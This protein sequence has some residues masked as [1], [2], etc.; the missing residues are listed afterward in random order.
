MLKKTI[1]EDC[2]L[3]TFA[4]ATLEF[5]QVKIDLTK[6]NQEVLDMMMSF[7]KDVVSRIQDSVKSLENFLN[8]V[9][10]RYS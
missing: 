4:Y 5:H 1:F 10:N 8:A 6:I 2:E 3:H 9:S 7:K